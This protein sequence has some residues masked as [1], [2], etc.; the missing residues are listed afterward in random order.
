MLIECYGKLKFP[1]LQFTHSGKALLITLTSFKLT[2]SVENSSGVNFLGCVH[3]EWSVGVLERINLFSDTSKQGC[4][5]LFT[6]GKFVHKLVTIT[7]CN[8]HYLPLKKTIWVALWCGHEVKVSHD[9]HWRPDH[10]QNEWLPW[11]R[12][13]CSMTLC[14]CLHG[15][16]KL[17][18]SISL[19][20]RVVSSHPLTWALCCDHH[21]QVRCRYLMNYACDSRL[22][23]LSADKYVSIN[24]CLPNPNANGHL[25]GLRPSCPWLPP[26]S[27]KFGGRLWQ[28]VR[29]GCMLMMWWWSILVGALPQFDWMALLRGY[30][31]WWR[32]VRS[33]WRFDASGYL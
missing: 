29:D 6:Q 3:E 25:F 23:V 14:H 7:A 2:H 31:C 26:T 11:A 10:Y 33:H 15:R 30:T 28:I 5:A 21:A 1:L 20:G 18:H 19:M 27:L 12:A 16:A 13:T 32:I 8:Y 9:H 17:S 24:A 22:N 4:W